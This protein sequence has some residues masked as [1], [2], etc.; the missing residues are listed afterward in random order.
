[1]DQTLHKYYYLYIL[2]YVFC[3][4]INKT[5]WGYC[6]YA[7]EELVGG[8]KNSKLL[9]Q[10]EYRQPIAP[11]TIQW[12]YI[13]KIVRM[14]FCSEYYSIYLFSALSVQFQILC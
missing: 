12:E 14:R 9:I 10:V 11:K 4:N 6:S 8:K 2:K 13:T 3:V 7:S 1:M 5:I